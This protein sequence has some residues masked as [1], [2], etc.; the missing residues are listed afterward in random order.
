MRNLVAGLR[1]WEERGGEEGRK[2]WMFDQL[3]ISKSLL[4]VLSYVCLLLS[5][6]VQAD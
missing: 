5:Y 2:D 4:L 6:V 1:D 3:M